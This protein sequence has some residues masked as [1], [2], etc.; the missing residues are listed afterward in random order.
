MKWCTQRRYTADR[1]SL[2][3]AHRGNGIAAAY[4]RPGVRARERV[5]GPVPGVVLA[6]LARPGDRPDGE[7]GVLGF[8]RRGEES[9]V[10]V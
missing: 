2:A 4:A 7:R 8:E 10:E 3:R 5:V 1:A 6:R 9:T